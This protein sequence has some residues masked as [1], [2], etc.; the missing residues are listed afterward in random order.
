MG[1]LKLT[2][3]ICERNDF[4]TFDLLAIQRSYEY[5]YK[6]MCNNERTIEVYR[7]RPQV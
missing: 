2:K 7:C 3:N 5:A 1:S 6:S 4:L